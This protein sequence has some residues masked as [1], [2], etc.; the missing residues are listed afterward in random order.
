MRAELVNRLAA[1]GVRGS[2]RSAS[3]TRSVCRRWPA[4]K[5]SSP[6]SSA[7]RSR[8]RRARPE[9][10]G[11]RPPARNGSRRGAL[12]LR[13]DREFNQRNSNASV[14]ESQ[15]PAASSSARTPTASA[16]P[17]RS[18]RRSAARSRALS[19][20]ATCS[21][22][23]RFAAAGTD[24]IVFADTVGVGVPRQARHSSR[25]SCRSACRSAS[26]CTTRETPASRTRLQRSRPAR[27]CS[28]PR[29]GD[30]GLPFAP[31]ATGNICTEDLVYLLHGEGIQTGIDLDALIGVAAGS[32]ACSGASFQ[33]RSTGP[34]L[35]RRSRLT[36]RGQRDGA[37]ARSGR[38]GHL[39]RPAPRG[40][41]QRRAH[42]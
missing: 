22:C 23:R 33:G 6:G 26:T 35:L 10:E 34:G 37:Q 29:W 1:A 12:R 9:R 36:E 14:E 5:R 31:K 7:S 3:S 38:R 17:S 19:T 21:T 24:E 8:L 20:R 15:P 18:A 32:R 41:R 11:L 16:R 4:P 27:P 39:H 13:R 25:G 40:R 2:R 42:A 28:T 30:R